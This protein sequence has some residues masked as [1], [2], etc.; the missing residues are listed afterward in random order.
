MRLKEGRAFSPIIATGLGRN[1]KYPLTNMNFLAIIC[2]YVLPFG[3][4]MNYDVGR[5]FGRLTVQSQAGSMRRCVCDCGN[6]TTVRSDKLRT[7]TTKSCGC[8][9]IE[10]HQQMKKDAAT[11]EERK[12][13][14]AVYYM[15]ESER[16]KT[17]ATLWRKNNREKSS[18]YQKKYREEKKAESADKRKN[19]IRIRHINSRALKKGVSGR[20][21]KEIIARLYF[22][23]HGACMYC[24]TSLDPGFHADHRMPLALKGMN[25]WDNIQLLC[26]SCNCRKG[27]KHPDEFEKEIDFRVKI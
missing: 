13:K 22:L 14:M 9:L 26:P 21:T 8:L 23:Q 12:I 5:R 15:K 4:A 10:T 27:K 17:A 24:G 1:L 3:G 2:S 6:E 19:R 25:T 11:P 18:A 7:G 20:L 16:I